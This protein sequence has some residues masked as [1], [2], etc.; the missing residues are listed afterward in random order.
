M[1]PS[2]SAWV[3]V[4][5][6][7]LR[8]KDSSR[9]EIVLKGARNSD[10]AAVRRMLDADSDWDADVRL[11]EPLDES[12]RPAGAEGHSRW[13]FAP[14]TLVGSRFEIVRPLGRGGMG[15]VYEAR[16]RVKNLAIAL[17]VLLP[18]P[19]MDSAT[20]DR[21]LRRE[22]ALAQMVSHRNICRIYDPYVHESDHH[23]AML[24]VSMELLKGKTLSAVLSERGRLGAEEVAAVARQLAAG[25]DAAHAAGVVHR[26]LKPSNVILVDDGGGQRV[27]IT[28]FGLARQAA[29]QTVSHLGNSI[30]GTLRY[31]A[32]EQRLSGTAAGGPLPVHPTQTSVKLSG[33]T[34]RLR[35]LFSAGSFGIEINYGSRSTIRRSISPSPPWK[36]RQS[37]SRFNRISTAATS[38][39]RQ[40]K[41]LVALWPFT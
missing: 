13:L 20:A 36:S 21:L 6:L 14:A 37:G 16:D 19:A 22:V 26:D 4:K 30:A 41:A 11:D 31:M 15:E 24:V 17:K 23:A 2:P 32:P 29:G 35:G 5:S 40:P 39:P 27:V 18:N 28:D 25:I 7:F 10:R 38:S 33:S 3:P 1:N 34:A 9:P 12:L 8:A